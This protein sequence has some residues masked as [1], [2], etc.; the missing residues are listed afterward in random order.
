MRQSDK[1]EKNHQICSTC[2]AAIYR[3]LLLSIVVNFV[4][5]V[6]FITTTAI[7]AVIRNGFTIIA[8][9]IAVTTTAIAVVIA[10]AIDDRRRWIIGHF[11]IE[12]LFLCLRFD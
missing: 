5:I 11:T 1:R 4:V 2:N 8:I 7:A 6:G 9:A 12:F 3:L 10:V